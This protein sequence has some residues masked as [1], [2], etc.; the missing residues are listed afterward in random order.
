MMWMAQMMA[1]LVETTTQREIEMMHTTRIRVA[2]Q[3]LTGW[4]DG[5]EDTLDVLEF[6]RLGVLLT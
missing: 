3:G 2:K 1:G 5:C 6:T 4:M